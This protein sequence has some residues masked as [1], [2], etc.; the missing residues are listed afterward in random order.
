[1][2]FE[3][4]FG[5][6]II[7][8]VVGAAM[9][10]LVKPEVK[11][12]T[13]KKYPKHICNLIGIIGL[14]LYISFLVCLSIGKHQNPT[15]TYEEVPIEKLTTTHVYFDDNSQSLNESYVVLEKPNEEYNNVVVVATEHYILQWISKIELSGNKYHIYLSEDIYNRLQDGS[16]IYKAE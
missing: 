5:I 16:T 14:A 9:F 10:F 15:F 7:S 1:M 4:A 13:N 3:V 2:S 11:R 8:G 12:R 6:A